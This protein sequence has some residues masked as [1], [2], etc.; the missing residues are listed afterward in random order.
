ME[1]DIRW[2]AA[3]ENLG[4]P[5]ACEPRPA[6][7]P[8]ISTNQRAGIVRSIFDVFEH[9]TVDPLECRE[10]CQLSQHFTARFCR[11]AYPIRNVRAKLRHHNYETKPQAEPQQSRGIWTER[12]FLKGFLVN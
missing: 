1:S 10:N 9:L 2:S 8:L 3:D 6:I 7:P 4:G 11:Q 12:R 5:S